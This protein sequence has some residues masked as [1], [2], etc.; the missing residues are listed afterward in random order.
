[1]ALAAVETFVN[2]EPNL[3]PKDLASIEGDVPNGLQVGRLEV[4]DLPPSWHHS[5]DERLRRFGD[6]RVRSTRTV[7]L[8]VPSA[9]V[10]GE[11]NILLNPIHQEFSKVKFQ[12]PKRFEF[13]AR[14]FR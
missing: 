14:M 13:D 8:L 6:G 4:K 10:P 7:A 12:V 1:M 9:A 5:R 2:L 3:Q 11:W